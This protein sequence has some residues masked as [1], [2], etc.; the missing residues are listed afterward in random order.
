VLTSNTDIPAAEIA[1]AYK[2]LRENGADL[3]GAEVH[4]VSPCYLSRS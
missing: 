1:L 2:S 3:P 4:A